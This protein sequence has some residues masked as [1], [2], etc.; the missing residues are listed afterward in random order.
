MGWEGEGWGSG[1]CEVKRVILTQL[2][3]SAI[4]LIFILTYKLDEQR[5]GRDEEI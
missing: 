4:S 2:I 5:Q 1:E 3:Q